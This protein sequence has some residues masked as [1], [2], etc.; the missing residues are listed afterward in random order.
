ML[1]SASTTFFILVGSSTLAF[2]HDIF[3]T[4]PSFIK[5]KHIDLV[6]NKILYIIFIGIVYSTCKIKDGVHTLLVIKVI[7]SIAM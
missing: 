3:L 1:M 7:L 6:Y 4:Q 2:R 5:K